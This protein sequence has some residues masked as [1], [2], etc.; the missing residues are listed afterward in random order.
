MPWTVRQIP[1][2]KGKLAIITGATGGLGYETAVALARENAEVILTGRNSEKGRLAVEKIVRAIPTANARFEAL[3]LAN[4]ASIHAFA[5]KM[6]DRAQ[7]IDILINNAGVMAPPTRRLTSD[8]FELQFGTNHLGHFALT[9]L[10]LPLL[11]YGSAARV[12]NV[13]SLAHRG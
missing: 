7:P 5:E 12:V 8:G 10:L 13:S 9:R 6:L 2:Q 1:P 11:I 3:D 4:L